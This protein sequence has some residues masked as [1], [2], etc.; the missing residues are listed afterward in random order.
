LRSI[1]DALR[2]TFL[3]CLGSV[4]V[5]A[6]LSELHRSEIRE[7]DRA[8]LRKDLSSELGMHHRQLA[9]L[10]TVKTNDDGDLQ[11]P[12]IPKEHGVRK[13]NTIGW[14]TTVPWD[15]DD[16]FYNATITVRGS[17]NVSADELATLANKPCFVGSKPGLG[18]INVR[19]HFDDNKELATLKVPPDRTNKFLFCVAQYPYVPD[20]PP[21]LP[22]FPP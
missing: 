14:K 16:K 9:A 18:V 19:V 10:L 8:I 1:P 7:A 12:K 6:I 20:H 21:P 4:T 11:K 15:R 3:A 2:F 13:S 17:F 5:P 22:D